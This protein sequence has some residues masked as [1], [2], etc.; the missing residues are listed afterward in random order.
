MNRFNN[1][2]NTLLESTNLNKTLER[3]KEEFRKEREE[4]D[5][6]LYEYVDG[7]DDEELEEL[8]PVVYSH[9]FGNPK[10]YRD[11]V[12][13]QTTQDNWNDIKTQGINPS[14]KTRGVSNRGT[15]SAVF[16]SSEIDEMNS[17]GDVTIQIDL[18]KVPDIETSLEEPIEEVY[19]KNQV[20][21]MM[22]PESEP[23]QFY[24]DSSDGLQDTTL[25][26]YGHIPNNAIELVE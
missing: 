24:V 25:V 17:Y 16:T 13:H 21:H 6:T 1:I 8:V 11:I 3:H 22:D 5:T 4:W 26:V 19:R 12:Y 9:H 2:I 15:G 23:Y 10:T 18:S 20:M 7:L 14:N